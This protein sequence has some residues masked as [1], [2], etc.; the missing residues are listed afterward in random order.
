MSNLPYSYLYIIS[1]GQSFKIGISKEPEKRLRQ[2]Q[3]GS[4][5]KIEIVELFCLPENIIYRVEKECHVRI[6]SKYCK[7]GEWFMGATKFHIQ[8]LVSE[9]CDPYIN[10]H[11]S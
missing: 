4:P 3:T 8:V 11:I 6:Q 5:N 2:L 9:I 1:D 7:R 10:G